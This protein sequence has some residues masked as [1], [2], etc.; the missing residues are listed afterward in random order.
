VDDHEIIRSLLERVLRSQGHT[1]MTAANGPEALALLRKHPIDLVI[2][3]VMMPEM[4]GIEVLEHI[5]A[6]PATHEIPV[7]VVSADTDT[8]KVVGG[9]CGVS[10]LPRAR[11][12]HRRHNVLSKMRDSER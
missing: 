11:L 10:D 2:L 6:N 8:D 5:K 9:R 3:D 4:I 1:V 7:L 12:L